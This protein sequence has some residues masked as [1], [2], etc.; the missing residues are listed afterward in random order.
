MPER[1]SENRT[2]MSGIL[3]RRSALRPKDT[4]ARDGGTVSTST[5]KAAG[6]HVQTDSQ[7]SSRSFPR[8]FHPPF[9]LRL[10]TPV[11][12]SLPEAAA[13]LARAALYVGND[14][15]MTH[16][17]ALLGVPTVA[18]FGATDPRVWSP[19]GR[20][21]EIVAGTAPC[22]PCAEGKRR[23]CPDNICLKSIPVEEVLA[24]AKAML[25]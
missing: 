24:R 22:S 4:P 6:L 11:L 16:L 9:A 10:Y 19:R 14:S 23:R 13:V 20:R 17:A 8:K 15:G 18:L 1:R 7:P 2:V 3:F 25:P 12:F 21:V 5:V